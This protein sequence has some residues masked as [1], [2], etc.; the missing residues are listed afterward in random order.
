MLPLKAAEWEADDRNR[1]GK[2]VKVLSEKN[3]YSSSNKSGTTETMLSSLKIRDGSF[4]YTK[5]TNNN[6][7]SNGKL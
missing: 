1:Y 2:P 4:F 5:I 3:Y 7:G 6:G